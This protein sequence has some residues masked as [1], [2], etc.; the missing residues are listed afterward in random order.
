MM[1]VS[2]KKLQAA[3]EEIRVKNDMI[4]IL[5]TERDYMQNRLDYSAKN[6]ADLMKECIHKRDRINQLFAAL[7]EISNMPTPSCAHIGKR[8]A[9]VA[10]RVL[11]K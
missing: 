5:T 3:F 1:F 9:D 2:K 6:Y 7:T 8:M 4:D 11:G 10:D